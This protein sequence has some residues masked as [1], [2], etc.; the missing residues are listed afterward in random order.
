MIFLPNIKAPPKYKGPPPE[1]LKI[2]ILH[3]GGF[4]HMCIDSLFIAA[5]FQRQTFGLLK[6]IEY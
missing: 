5:E 3:L 4:K 6:N 2:L 1:V